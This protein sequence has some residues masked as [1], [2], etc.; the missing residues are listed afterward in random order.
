[1][2]QDAYSL[3]CSPQAHGPIY[4]CLER[5]EEEALKVVNK[6]QMKYIQIG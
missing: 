5:L 2:A 3:R 4:D 6:P 1:M